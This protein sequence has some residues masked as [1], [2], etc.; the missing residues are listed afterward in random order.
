MKTSFTGT[1]LAAVLLSGCLT[2]AVSAEN[3][4]SLSEQEQKAGFK[5][6]ARRELGCEGRCDYSHRKGRIACL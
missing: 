5:L 1:S 2:T 4:N 6:A 3:P